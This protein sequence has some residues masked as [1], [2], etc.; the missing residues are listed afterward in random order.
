LSESLVPKFA[1]IAIDAFWRFN[2][3]EGWALASHIA[4]S[5]LMALFPFLIFV[6][7]LAALFGSQDMADQLSQLLLET[8]PAQVAAPI[9]A[10]LHNVL[11]NV[12]T[13]ALTFGVLLAIYFSSSGV[14]SLRIALNRAYELTEERSFWILKLEAIA[15]VLVGAMGLISLGFLIVLW[16]LAWAL[17]ARFVPGWALANDPTLIVRY[18]VAGGMLVFALL[19]VHMW[20]PAGRRRIVEVVPGIVVTILLWLIM[21]AAFGEY[22]SRFSS[23]VTTYA[24][25]ASVMAALVFLYLTA[26]I[27]IYGGEV[28]A[29]LQDER[30]KAPAA[31]KAKKKRRKKE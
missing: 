3:D 13:D 6:T 8:W 24:G 21:G 17:L 27:F 12:R 26:S 18:T 22:L 28:N 25:L 16:P 10:E 9:A 15:Y 14:E 23:Y 31:A 30:R 19:V 29:V 1:R 4:L 7:S 5:L 11:T 20:L 2:A